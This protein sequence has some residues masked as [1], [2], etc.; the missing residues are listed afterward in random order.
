MLFLFGIFGSSYLPGQ[1]QNMHRCMMHVYVLCTQM[2]TKGI[3]WLSLKSQ[4]IVFKY[5]QHIPD[6]I[7]LSHNFRRNLIL[8]FHWV[9]THY[10]I[11][12]SLRARILLVN[13]CL[14]CGKNICLLRNIWK[15]ICSTE[16]Q[17]GQS[18]FHLFLLLHQKFSNFVTLHFLCIQTNYSKTRVIHFVLGRQMRTPP[19][20][21]CPNIPY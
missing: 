7:T 1:S 20:K 3:L 8:S 17:V 21:I 15:N 2:C 18:C 14:L 6:K 16:E 11:S 9:K 12:E 13:W 4:Q 5:C 19:W 10:P